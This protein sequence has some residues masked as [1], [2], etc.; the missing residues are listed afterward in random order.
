MTHLIFGGAAVGSNRKMLIEN[1]VSYLGLSYSGLRKR[2]LPT[3]KTW[4]ASEHFPDGVL[5]FLES[6]SSSIDKEAKSKDEIEAYA[7]EY[8]QFVVNNI[9]RIS[10]FTELDSQVMGLEWV[11]QQRKFYEGDEK[12]WPV[13][14]EAHGLGILA[15]LA[16]AH[17]NV[18]IP[19]ATVEKLTNLASVTRSYQRLFGTKFHGL[20]IAKPD[21]L[22]Q[23]PFETAS[24]LAWLSPMK[25]RETIVW[26]GS[27]IV[28]YPKKM[29]AQARPRY[30]AVV[31]SMGLDFQAFMQ[32]TNY[33]STKVAIRSYLELEKTMKD[34]PPILHVIDGGKDSKNPL[35]VD[36]SDSFEV[37]FSGI[38][39]LTPDNKGVEMR[40]SAPVEL[41]QRAPEEMRNLPGFDFKTKS[42]KDINS[43]GHIVFRDVQ[44]AQ[45]TGAS[46]RQCNNCFVAANC[47]AFK[48]NNSCAFN[49]PIEVKTKEQLTS[50]LTAILEMQGTRVAFLRFAEETAGGGYPDQNLS[51]EIDRLFK[52]VGSIQEM[53]SDKETV[54]I[55]AERS[56]AGGVLSA[57]FGDRAAAVRDLNKPLNEIETTRIIAESIED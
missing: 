6:G 5:I 10:G 20:G 3:K 7:A 53:S 1:G 17:K 34:K 55:T 21:N 27:R 9:D 49:F 14:H 13:F 52:L 39:E 11:E 45:S 16:K 4:L 48:P 8:Q 41:V 54:R 2:G 42:I 23:I 32:D 51:Q 25:R 24:T 28:R 44:V 15:D 18:A 29:K 26:D 43:E 12:M 33:E 31:D 36:N 57:L 40:N 47:P 30:K 50:F 38:P 22:R 37:H 46:L 19:H 56:S 35:I